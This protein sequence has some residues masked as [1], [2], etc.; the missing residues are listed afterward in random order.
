MDHMSLN[1]GLGSHPSVS[2]EI[3]ERVLIRNLE[4]M[5]NF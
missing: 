2:L 4:G 1:T 5:L 3:Q